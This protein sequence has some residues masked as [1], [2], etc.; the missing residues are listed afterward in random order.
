MFSTPI[1]LPS[2]SGKFVYD[3]TLLNTVQFYS[4]RIK[5]VECHLLISVSVRNTHTP[6][7]SICGSESEK[8]RGLFVCV[9][10]DVSRLW[11]PIRKKSDLFHVWDFGFFLFFA[12]AG[13]RHVKYCTIM[14]NGLSLSSPIENIFYAATCFS[15]RIW[16]T[17]E[18]NGKIITHTHTH[19]N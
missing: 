8:L 2:F 13:K 1:V 14:V 19:K 3:E 15:Q 11:N 16:Q 12:A 4:S 10:V 9:C 17:R 7:H 6:T 18:A 5:R